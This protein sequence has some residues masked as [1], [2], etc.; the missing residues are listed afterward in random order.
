MRN[1]KIAALSIITFVGLL[2]TSLVNIL[3]HLKV[4]LGGLVIAIPQFL[5][6]ALM[7]PVLKFWNEVDA[8]D[9]ITEGVFSALP[10]K[11]LLLF[12]PVVIYAFVN[13]FYFMGEISKTPRGEVPLFIV[14]GFFSSIQ[15]VF[16][17]FEFVVSI[18][19]KNVYQK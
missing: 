15:L 14:S 1:F 19:L 2:G 12:V 8:D 9:Q 4:E 11:L 7:Y 5:A 6:I 16:L 13:A 3:S 17:S 18:G 10:G